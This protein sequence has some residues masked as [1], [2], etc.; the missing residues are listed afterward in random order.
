MNSKEISGFL[1]GLSNE[2]LYELRDMIDGQLSTRFREPSYGPY[3]PGIISVTIPPSGEIGAL[4][5]DLESSTEFGSFDHETAWDN[6]DPE[7]HETFIEFTDVRDAQN[8][9]NK[10]RGIWAITLEEP[11][12]QKG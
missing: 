5:D 7:S 3:G 4:V 2:Q 9:V 10:L 1:L 12:L 11:E 8:A 6:Y